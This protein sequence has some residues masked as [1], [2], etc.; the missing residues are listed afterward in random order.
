MGVVV[1]SAY[2]RQTGGAAQGLQDLLRGFLRRCGPFLRHGC[3]LPDGPDDGVGQ[4]VKIQVGCAGQHA[5]QRGHLRPNRR[6]EVW[7]REGP[8]P[9]DSAGR[10]LDLH[11]QVGH[12]VAG[13]VA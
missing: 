13:H 7:S 12:A 1:Q 9:G 3:R 8:K 4:L 6:L 11:Q 2:H 5:L 10:I